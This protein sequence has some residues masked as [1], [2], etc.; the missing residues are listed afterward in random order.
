MNID[1]IERWVKQ[2][3][4]QDPY[5]LEP[6]LACQETNVSDKDFNDNIVS[7]LFSLCPSCNITAFDYTVRFDLCATNL[8]KKLFDAHYDDDT[9]IITSNNE[10]KNVQ[11]IIQNKNVLV[12]D[13]DTEIHKLKINRVLSYTKRYK[14][15]IVYIIGTQ[16]SSGIITPNVFF[17]ML[18]NTLELAGCN[19]TLIIDDVQGMYIVPRDYSI[20]DYIIGTAHSVI[21]NFD[22]GILIQK[23]SNNPIGFKYYE[24]SADYIKKMKIFLSNNQIAL[25]QFYSVMQEAF[26]VELANPNTKIQLK[27]APNIFNIQLGSTVTNDSIHFSK[28]D[29]ALFNKYF[30]HLEGLDG[31]CINQSIRFRAQEFLYYWKNVKK[32]LYLL[33]EYIKDR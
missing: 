20:F 10:H 18:K 26:S 32:G 22:M 11:D 30:I 5:T 24:S 16:L 33:Q 14:K 13:Q 2:F 1:T 21:G 19:T 15:I 8:I 31:K 29:E 4:P 25:Y 7:E 9:L 3:L 28:S 23:N 12:L 6:N 17:T 27:S